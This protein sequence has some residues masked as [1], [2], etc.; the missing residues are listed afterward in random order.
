MTI[1]EKFKKAREEKNLKL[2][3]IQENIKIRIRYLEAL[4]SDQFD[5]IPGEAY[6]RVFIKGYANFLD[7][8]YIELLEQY[9][10]MRAEEKREIE[11][12]QENNELDKKPGNLIHRK[13]LISSIIIGVIIVI[14]AFLIYNI[15]LLNDSKNNNLTIIPSNNDYIKTVTDDINLQNQQDEENIHNN[16]SVNVSSDNSTVDNN[17]IH[18]NTDII[19]KEN[20]DFEDS[21][22]D[23]TLGKTYNNSNELDTD[24]KTINQQ[25]AGNI[26]K[27][28][29]NNNLLLKSEAEL[30]NIDIIVTEKSWIQI[31]IDDVKVYEGI[32][33]TGDDKSYSYTDNISMKIGNAAGIKVR[34]GNRVLGPWGE[35]GEVIKK[36]IED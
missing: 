15:F 3:E 8:D 36:T 11:K 14:I 10:M 22:T 13:K 7:L 33:N 31:H 4:E 18:N 32:L 6:V 17:T 30:Q 16:N 25:S 12:S 21:L 26:E 27:F 19:N 9:E 5:V 1:G 20:L 24:E 34:R 28:E 29:E 23:I 2:R 35:Q